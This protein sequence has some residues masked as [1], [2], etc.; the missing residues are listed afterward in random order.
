MST[1]ADIE[2]LIAAGK[3]DE[4][5]SALDTLEGATADYLRGRIA[6]KRGDRAGAIAAYCRSAALDPAGPGATALAQA[7]E[8]MNFFNKDLYNP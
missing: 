6:W 8:I 2:A 3:L 7:R 5:T 1:R 4:A